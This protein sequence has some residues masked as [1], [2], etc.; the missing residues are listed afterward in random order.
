MIN[1]RNSMKEYALAV[2]VP[3]LEAAAERRLSKRPCDV[4]DTIGYVSTQLEE[5]FRPLWGLAPILNEQKI[6]LNI[7]KRQVEVGDWLREVLITGT[8][9]DSEFSWDKNREY[10]GTH[11]FYFQN[12]TELAGLLVCCF[13]SRKSTW[14]KLSYAEQKQVA[15]YIAN[16]CR[17]LCEKIAGNNH[18]W[19]PLLCLIVLRKLGFDYPDTDKYINEGLDKLDS[20]YVGGGWYSDGDFGRID[21]YIAW[22]MHSY[23]LL[24]C[25][26]EDESFPSYAKRRSLYLERTKEFLSDYSKFF[27]TDGA[28]PPFGRSLAYRFAASCV[29]PLAILAGVDFDAATAGEITRRNV[30]YFRDNMLTEENNILKPGFLYNAPGLVD[31]YTSSGGPYWAAKTFMCLLLPNSHPFWNSSS[32]PIDR[33]SY[34]SRPRDERLNFV[35]SGNKTSGVTVY[36][37]HFQYYQNGRYCNPFNDMACSYDKFCYNSRSGFALSTRDNT[38]SDNMISLSTKDRSMTSHRWGF[39]D[40]GRQGD[41]MISEHT[42][43]SNDPDTLIQTWM[44]PIDGSV[45]IRVHRVRLSGEYNLTEGGFSLGLWDDYRESD[46]V[47][48]AFYLKNHKSISFIKAVATAEISYSVLKQQPGMH[49]LAPFSLYPAYRTVAPLDKGEYIFAS[50]FGICDLENKPLLPNISIKSNSV[51]V[52]FN[53]N[54]YTIEL[55]TSH[56]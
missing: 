8:D 54:K 31:S 10:N 44:L 23:P 50:A 55:V 40:L 47:D 6:Y 16:G 15:D 20:M 26:I 7:R 32:L 18:I 25:M 14:D 33:E 35:F 38:S 2:C 28:Y 9:P 45:H 46:T 13:F 17:P 49:L 4:V 21:Y 56:D 30:S 53:N 24:W 43:F 12:I 11:S 5:L 22:S 34:I 41:V 42:P 48:N 52:D 39:T 29:F 37:N 1:D 51:T 36:N 3:M 19:F 27:D